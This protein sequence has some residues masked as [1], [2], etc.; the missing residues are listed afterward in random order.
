MRHA[1]RIVIALS[2]LVVMASC[3]RTPEGSG[4]GSAPAPSEG[5]PG[6]SASASVARIV[7]V[8]QEQACD[9]TAARIEGSWTALQ[10]ALGQGSEVPVERIHRDTQE[11]EADQY[12]LLRPMVTVPGIY[13]LDE[14]G[15]V[16]ELLQ[17]EVTEEQL[18]QALQGA[19]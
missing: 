8:D 4:A 12:R 14:G 19:G 7:F 18:R 5:A 15:A 3:G 1:A 10:A 16:M 2:A 6:T 11:Q 13:L 17:G 9:C